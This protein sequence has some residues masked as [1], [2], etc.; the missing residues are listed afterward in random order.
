ME[1]RKLK[2]QKEYQWIIPQT[3]DMIVPG[4]IFASQQL[5]EEMDEK[6]YEQVTNVACLPGLQRFS[7]AMPDAH[8]GYGF[9]IGG[10]AAF[11][12]QEGGVVSVGGVGFDVNCGVRTL[13]TGMV[14]EDIKPHLRSIIDTLFSIVPAG[15]GSRGEISLSS[16]QIQEVL[17]KGAQWVVSRGY[18]TH[19]DL[20]FTEDRGM[21]SGADPSAVSEV[22]LRRERRQ[23]GTLGSGNHYLEIQ[24]VD[25]IYNPEVAQ[26][27][28]LAVD[29]VVVTIHCGSRALGHQVGTDYLKSLAAASRK[30]G[31]PIREREL[32]CAP[33]NSPEGRQYFSAVNCAINYAFANRQ[34]ITHLVRL[35]FE[36]VLPKVEIHM[37]YDIGHN[38][39]KVERHQIDGQS[40]EVYVHRKGATRAFGASRENIPSAYRGVGQPVIVGGTMGTASYILVGTEYG[41]QVAFA[42]VCHGAGRRMSRKKAKKTWR[43]DRLVRELEAKGIYVRGHSFAGLAEEAPGAY[44]DVSEVIEAIHNAGLASKVARLQPMGCIK[45]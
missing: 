38:T 13:K 32:V 41:E 25:E 37:L 18:G 1:L 7:I 22:A 10:V 3:G 24:R 35:G 42:S 14:W 40:K 15:V 34:V 8:W 21:V 17:T 30:Y 36:K 31:I 19:E 6:V 33:I 43:G 44:K 20:D 45:G 26:K 29:D 11:D 5:I 9:P 28:G 23:V 16:S 39:C 4:Q 12:P 27:F 2:R